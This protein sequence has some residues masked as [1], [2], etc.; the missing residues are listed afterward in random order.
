MA[1]PRVPFWEAICARF[2][3][4]P[5]K[6]FACVPLT[7]QVNLPFLLHGSR[8]RVHVDNRFRSPLPVPARIALVDSGLRAGPNMREFTAA[9]MSFLSAWAPAVLVAPLRLALSLA[10]EKRRGSFSVPSLHT[11]IVV[12]T[13][14]DEA[15][16][17]D[18]HRDL[19]WSAFGV[20]IFEQLRGP[21]G[22]IIARECEVH[23]GLHI[24]DSSHDLRGDIVT[25]PCACGSEAPRLR[26]MLTSEKSAVA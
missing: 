25:D 23:D 15:P 11:A 1:L 6:T 9:E 17:D 2:C 8:R 22:A 20:P 21:D 14:V 19:L 10:D 18:C 3:G 24:V 26:S 16:L 5:E 13:S 7:H 12:L 4:N